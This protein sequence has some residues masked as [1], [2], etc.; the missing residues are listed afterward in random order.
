MAAAPP[1]P[2]DRG[3]MVSRF[4]VR[5]SLQNPAQLRMHAGLDIGPVGARVPVY[6]ITSGT[7]E[8]VGNNANVNDPLSGYGN[9]VAIR[10]DGGSVWILYAHMDPATVAAG[11][12]VEAGQQ[13]GVVSNTTNGSFSPLPSETRAQWTT[14]RTRESGR[15]PRF[16]NPHLHLEVRRARD[17]GSSPFLPRPTGYPD[18]P[19]QARFNLDPQQWLAAKGL[20][21]GAR[22]LME[23]VP[24]S[25]MDQSRAQWG[26][27][28]GVLAVMGLGSADGTGKS[29]SLATTGSSSVAT[30]SSGGGG[31]GYEPPVQERSART[32][33]TPT[34]VGGIIAASTVVVG[35]VGAV[36]ARRAMTSNSRSTR[37]RRH[38]KKNR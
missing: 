16:M 6:A 38:R 11:Q 24:G 36:V 10:D 8:R 13:I 18:T 35:V 9:A 37:L 5:H 19:E 2:L 28:H 23:V 33:L 12:H 3:R 7:V 31:S 1:L 30:T 34:E 14:R 22:G 21:F 32:G 29:G 25:E 4:G 27:L 15:A 26:A 20:V 17:D